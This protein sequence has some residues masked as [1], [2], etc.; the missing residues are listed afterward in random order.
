VTDTQY[1]TPLNLDKRAS[2]YAKFGDRSTSGWSTIID[3]L[4]ALNLPSDAHLVD[5]GG[6][7]GNIWVETAARIP[8][9]WRIAH[10]DLSPGMI[11]AARANI[12][13]HNSTFVVADIQTLP[14]DTSSIDAVTALYVMYHVRDR[15]RAY[16]EVSRVLKRRGTFVIVLPSQRMGSQLHDLAMRFNETTRE[17]IEPWPQLDCSAETAEAELA[18]HFCHVEARR[19]E[20]RLLITEAMPLADYLTSRRSV[21]ERTYRT[22]CQFLNRMI[23][24]TGPISLY[25]ETA[26]FLA[27]TGP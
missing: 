25:P 12:K 3:A 21:D 2:I 4:L 7:H 13:R 1:A 19:Q 5:T 23:N 17:S 14:F 24:E 18:E 27:R 9:G 26:T 8:E 22:L 11:G 20:S 10:T 15:A 6:G 16:R